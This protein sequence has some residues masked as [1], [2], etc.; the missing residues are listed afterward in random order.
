[1]Q[2]TNT[3]KWKQEMSEDRPTFSE[4]GEENI[5]AMIRRTLRRGSLMSLQCHDNKEGDTKSA[6]QRRG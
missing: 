3:E 5:R 6:K 4:V 2:R 1:M